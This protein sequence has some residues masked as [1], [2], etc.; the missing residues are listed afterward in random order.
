MCPLTAGIAASWLLCAE[1]YNAAGFMMYRGFNRAGKRIER[2]A[3]ILGKH[4]DGSVRWWLCGI[5]SLGAYRLS[6]LCVLQIHAGSP[7]YVCQDP[8]IRD[9]GASAVGEVERLLKKWIKFGGAVAQLTVC[10]LPLPNVHVTIT[11]GAD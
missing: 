3:A 6:T 10:L 8:Q 9:V 2:S 5:A 1:K 11:A 4:L 7:Y